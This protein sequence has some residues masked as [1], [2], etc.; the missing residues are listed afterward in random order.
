MLELTL[1]MPSLCDK[2]KYHLNFLPSS[3]IYVEKSDTNEPINPSQQG[4]GWLPSGLQ[5]EVI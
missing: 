2:P 5:V 4:N 1:N 3:T